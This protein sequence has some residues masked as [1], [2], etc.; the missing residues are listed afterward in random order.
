VGVKS[1]PPLYREGDKYI[2]DS[3]ELTSC[4][5]KERMDVNTSV[6]NIS[7]GRTLIRDCKRTGGSHTRRMERQ[8]HAKNIPIMQTMATAGGPREG[9][10][11]G[12]EKVHP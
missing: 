5:Y 8:F 9:G 2:M 11:A 7:T 3:T 10:L 12:M 6:L 1:H 4:T